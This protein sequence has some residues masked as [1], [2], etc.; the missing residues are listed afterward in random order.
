MHSSHLQGGLFVVLVALSM[1]FAACHHEAEVHARYYQLKGTVISVDRAHQ[2]IIVNHEAIPG[3]MSAMIMPYTVK[4]DGA[5]DDLSAGDQITARV[6]VM[7]N[8]VWLD[9]ILVLKRATSPH[10]A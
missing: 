7:P 9:K 5:L 8:D 6:V 4:E 10:A 2:Q 1:P 3:F